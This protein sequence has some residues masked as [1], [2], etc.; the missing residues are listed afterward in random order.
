VFDA[1]GPAS[2][3]R[4]YRRLAATG[5]LVVYGAHGLTG[6]GGVRRLR[7]G[8]DYLTRPRFDP[9]RLCGDNRGVLGFNLAWLFDRRD[10]LRADLDAV[11]AL[12]AAGRIRLPSLTTLPLREVAEAH[13]RLESGTTVGKLVLMTDG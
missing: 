10:T 4:S 5:R 2:W 6:G 1:Q 12:V 9:M 7:G 8:W 11:L 13:R 3:R